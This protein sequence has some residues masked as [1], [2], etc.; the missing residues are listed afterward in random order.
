MLPLS[1]SHLPVLGLCWSLESN[2]G[3]G[4]CARTRSCICQCQ[5]VLPPALLGGCHQAGVL[6]NKLGLRSSS[7]G[8]WACLGPCFCALPPG[9]DGCP[10]IV[11][12]GALHA[13]Q[14]GTCGWGGVGMDRRDA[15]GVG[16][17]AQRWGEGHKGREMGT[18]Q[19]RWAQNRGGGHMYGRSKRSPRTRIYRWAS[20]VP[21]PHCCGLWGSG[22]GREWFWHRW[23]PGKGGHG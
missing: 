9:A 16:R 17:R 19:G 14:A 21:A 10:K 1:L 20:P 6:Y 11:S 8:G 18:K 15:H 12:F 23:F 13:A 4:R 7:L 3:K 2:G 5:I 22:Q